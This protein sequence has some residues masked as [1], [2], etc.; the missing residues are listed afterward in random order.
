[1]MHLPAAPIILGLFG[2]LLMIMLS[3]HATVNNGGF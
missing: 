1:M 2:I 3:I